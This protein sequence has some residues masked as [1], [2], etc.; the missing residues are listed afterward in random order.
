[1]TETSEQDRTAQI[2]AEA[3]EASLDTEEK[4]ARMRQIKKRLIPSLEEEYERLRD[5]LVES[6]EGPRHFIDDNEGK[7]IGFVV[8]PDKTVLHEE[9]LDELPASVVEEIAPRK[10]DRKKLAAAAASG[11]IEQSFLA[12]IMSI[13]TGGGTP[14]IRFLEVDAKAGNEE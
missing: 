4:L 10:I 3:R 2:I 6:M 12:R 1:M 13:R 9:I 11:R 8:R 5:A 7:L 14:H